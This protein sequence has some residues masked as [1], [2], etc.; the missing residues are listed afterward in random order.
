FP[1][2]RRPEMFAKI[3]ETLQYGKRTGTEAGGELLVIAVN[4]A[5]R[6]QGVG[7]QL[8]SLLEEEFRRRSVG[9]YQVTVHSDREAAN[10]FYHHCGFQ[11]EKKFK[12]YG[13]SWDLYTKHLEKE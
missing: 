6:G 13:L 12:L 7:R 5:Q 2:I 1:L 9:A 4:A 11:S 8:V 10:R 3:L